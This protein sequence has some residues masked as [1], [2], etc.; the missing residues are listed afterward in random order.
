MPCAICANIDPTLNNVE[1]AARLDTS[2]ASIRRHKAAQHNALEQ[3][4]SFFTDVPS[5]MITSRGR[6][7]RLPDGSWEKVTWQP[8]KAVL[9]E[10]LS[11]DD[12]SD[13]L[14]SNPQPVKPLSSLL[15]R[16]LQQPEGV[17]VLCMTDLQAGKATERG[18]GTPETMA[19][20]RRSIERFKDKVV[21]HE[22]ETVLLVDDGDPIENVFNVGTQPHTNDL[23]VP[24][25]I[26]AARRIFALAI[27]EL[28]PHTRDLR[29]VSVPS[30]HG[31]FRTSLK[32]QGGSSDA[33]FGLEINYCLEEQFE[34]RPGFEHVTFV[35]PIPLEET[36]VVEA[37]G[38]RLAFA[39]G[40]QSGGIYKHGEWWAK[41]DH[42]RRPGWNADIFT[43][44]HFHTHV[45]YQSGDAR[46]VIGAASPDPGS[47][48]Y[49]DKTGETSERG[50]TYFFANNGALGDIGI[51]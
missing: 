51:V 30:N 47:K 50:L 13:I 10:A 40:H 44:G 32:T 42:G 35:R 48:W 12:L 16:E 29:F 45:Q 36:A 46:W 49:T 11:Y 7:T 15:G 41:Q 21:R 8:N 22:P 1:N 28:A 14:S 38:T 4:D 18:G 19:V 17:G 26:R 9:A 37:G 31:A 33:D 5:T 2:E 43:F 23:D 3:V 34:D 27:K 24:A 25:Q 20:V 6:S 39:H